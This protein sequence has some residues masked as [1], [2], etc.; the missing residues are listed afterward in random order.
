MEEDEEVR[1]AVQYWLDQGYEINELVVPAPKANYGAEGAGFYFGDK[2]EVLKKLMGWISRSKQGLYVF[3]DETEDQTTAWGDPSTWTCRNV[4]DSFGWDKKLDKPTNL[5]IF[6]VCPDTSTS[7]MIRWDSHFNVSKVPVPS[8]NES[9]WQKATAR[10]V[11][12]ADTH[13]VIE[14]TR[15]LDVPPPRGKDHTREW[16]NVPA[17][18]NHEA[19]ARE[20]RRA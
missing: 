9:W 13:D 7:Q 17:M 11:I 14:V 6:Y 12:D 2:E 15:M 4:V 20:G 19:R 1:K 3:N 16:P 5:Q 8:K 10:I 18:A